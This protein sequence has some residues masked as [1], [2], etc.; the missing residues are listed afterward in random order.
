MDTPALLPAETLNICAK[1]TCNFEKVVVR[2]VER[3]VESS[4]AAV[5]FLDGNGLQVR[6]LA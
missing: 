2:K 6:C 1:S 4:A 3:K 5:P